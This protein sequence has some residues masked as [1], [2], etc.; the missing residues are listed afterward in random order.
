MR[1]EEFAR[2]IQRGQLPRI[3]AINTVLVALDEVAAEYEPASHAVVSDDGQTMR[4]MLHAETGAVVAVELD[5]IR[6]ITLARE[7]IEAALP[8]LA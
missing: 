1:D 3:D 4:L 7:L 5:P 6:A 2:M 8:K